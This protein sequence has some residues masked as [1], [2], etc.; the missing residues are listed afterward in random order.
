MWWHTVTQGRR[1]E[2]ETREWNGWQ[3]SVTWLHNTGLHEQY[4]PCRLMCTVGLPAVDWTDSPANLNGLVRLAERRNVVSAHVPSH[5]KRSL[6]LLKWCSEDLA[7]ESRSRALLSWFLFS[8]IL[9]PPRI[10]GNYHHSKFNWP[11]PTHSIISLN[12]F[13]PSS[14]LHSNR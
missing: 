10:Y 7:I 1:S 6:T 5:F 3:V 13:L 12:D 9:I 4:K 2:G 8:L 14:C 11:R